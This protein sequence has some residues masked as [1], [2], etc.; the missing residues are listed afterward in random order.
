MLTI[1]SAAGRLAE[2][3]RQH[4]AFVNARLLLVLMF[5]GLWVVMAP[6]GLALP[7]G[8]L[9]ALMAETVALFAYKRLVPRADSV[10]ALTRLHYLLLAAEIGFHSTM[11]YYLGG[12]SWLGGVAYIYAVLYAAAFLRWWETA[13]FVTAVALVSGSMMT[14]D[15]LG[16]IPHQSFLPQ[17][18]DRFR[19][20]RFV[21]TSIIMFTGVLAT[22]AFWVSWLGGE[23]RRERDAALTANEKLTRTEADLRTLNEELEQK[24]EERTRVLL[25]RAEHDQLTGLLNR[26]SVSRRCQELLALAKRGERPMAL[27]VADADD[28]KS[29]ND[30]GGHAYGDGVLR[31]LADS[32]RE[33]CRESDVVGRLG[34]DE[35]LVLLPD[36]S[37][38][39]ALGYC[40]RLVKLI[41]QKQKHWSEKFLPLPAL[42]L[43][44]GVFPGHG[45][46]V[47]DL[48]RVADKAM[49]D[50]KAAGGARWKM[51]KSGATFAAAGRLRPR[52]AQ[53]RAEQ[54]ARVPD[55]VAD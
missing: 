25:F 16:V 27:I 7:T 53:R 36:T 38:R 26:G 6:V 32:L 45:V 8:F 23:M 50:A 17:G 11:V 3:K 39:G 13:I 1:T 14:F 12:A 18:V 33:S 10:G 54:A 37:V 34:G 4:G 44:I 49:Y 52:G 41:E 2:N 30:M 40:R 24:V 35:F 55:P 9:V 46:D 5:I 29:C 15:A 19:D 21:E 31:I 22:V 43:G 51:G 42:S 28:F 48:I 47:E 20:A